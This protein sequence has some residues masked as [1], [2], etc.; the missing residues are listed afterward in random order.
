[1]VNKTTVQ[2]FYGVVVMPTLSDVVD[3]NLTK[4]VVPRLSPINITLTISRIGPNLTNFYFWCRCDFG[5]GSNV[6]MNFLD[7][8]IDDELSIDHAYTTSAPTAYLNLTCY[9]DVSNKTLTDLIILETPVSNVSIVS[10]ISAYVTNSTASFYV[11]MNEGSHFNITTDYGD[12]T[13]V[14]YTMYAKS[15]YSNPIWLNH[16]YSHAGIYN[17]TVTVFNLISK[18][19]AALQSLITV[20]DII[21]GLKFATSAIN[22]AANEQLS[23]L[24]TLTA[25]TNVTFF[26]TFGTN[27]T[28][29]FMEFNPLAF[30]VNYTYTSTGNYTVNV[31]ASNLVSSMS[32]NCS[33]TVQQRIVSLV[34]TGNSSLLWTPGYGQY[35][36]SLGPSQPSLDDVFCSWLINSQGKLQ[37]FYIPTLDSNTPHI[38]GYS[39]NKSNIGQNHIDVN[40]SNLISWR[41]LTIQVQLV[42]DIPIL[43][44]LSSNTTST[45]W[46]YTTYFELNVTRYALG[47]SCFEWNMGDGTPNYIYGEPACIPFATLT[48]S[49]FTAI[50]PNSMTVYHSYVYAKVASYKVMARSYS[51]LFNYYTGMSNLSISVLKWVCL[52]PN[53]TINAS[54]TNV[55]SPYQ[56]YRS[57]S[58][59]ITTNVSMLCISG[60]DNYVWTV[61]NF[62]QRQASPKTAPLIATQNISGVF[63]YLANTW[64]YAVYD[65]EVKVYMS[66]PYF[67][68]TNISDTRHVYLNITRTPLEIT[69]DGGPYMEV[70]FN[71][72][73]TFDAL[74]YTS[75]PDTVLRPENKS[76]MAFQWWCKRQTETWPA[77]PLPA[78]QMDLFGK[79]GCFGLGPGLLTSTDGYLNLSTSYMQPLVNYT[80]HLRSTKDVRQSDYELSLYIKE[81]DPPVLEIK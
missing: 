62:Q 16:T 64:Q 2:N 40:C 49:I 17:V 52:K 46:N 6:S 19:T 74:N 9:N 70:P 53:L 11:Y 67:D 80:L 59:N 23:F 27:D 77:G 39:F 30:T 47:S 54:L 81:A 44:N 78:V 73:I 56:N 41:N 24:G 12:N 10:P 72:N 4:P 14:T 34:L 15:G 66:S 58:L 36:V 5:D 1:M 48:Q 63:S 79:T 55:L 33:V 8:E 35:A 45:Y 42:L 76:G 31:T 20:Q 69:F 18:E 51:T 22:A 65:I 28:Q 3:L 29:S 21:K 37:T 26:T 25:G 68:D 38:F 13:I 75:D 60:T 43:G 32:V 57:I 71:R 7:F 61:Y 50:S